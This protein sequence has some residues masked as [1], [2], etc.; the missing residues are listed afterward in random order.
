MLILILIAASDLILILINYFRKLQL[1]ISDRVPT[2]LENLE[3][4]GNFTNL[5][6][7]G[8]FI[9]SQ[10]IYNV[11]GISVDIDIIF[12]VGYDFQYENTLQTLFNIQVCYLTL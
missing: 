4:S 9:S 11:I 6:K 1:P 8:N 10:G 2:I 3:K 7:S 12:S 5:E